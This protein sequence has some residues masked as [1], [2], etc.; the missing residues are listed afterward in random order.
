MRLARCPSVKSSRSSVCSHKNMTLKQLF[1]LILSIALVAGAVFFS[2]NPN[3]K[4]IL[5][6]INPFQATL[7]PMPEEEINDAQEGLSED[8]NQLQEQF[9]ELSERFNDLEGKFLELSSINALLSSNLEAE[10]LSLSDKPDEEEDLE[11]GSN[12]VVSDKEQ[13]FCDVAGGAQPAKNTV[14][15]NE[16]AWMGTIVSANDEWLEMKNLSSNAINLEG[17]QILDKDNQIKIV[18]DGVNKISANNL[19]ILERTDDNSLPNVPAGRIYSGALSDSNEALYLF[20]QNCD[21][22]DTVT[23]NPDWFSGD[24]TTKRTMERKSDFSWQTSKDTGGTPNQENSSGYAGTFA[25]NN[26]NN[27]VSGSGG[28]GGNNTSPPPVV[29]PKLLISEVQIDPID[30][31]F[32][33]LYNPNESEVSLTGWYIQRKTETGSDWVSL[34]SSNQFDGKIISAQSHFLIAENGEGVDIVEALTVTENN[35]LILKNPNRDIVDK[36]GFGAAQDF[37]TAPAENPPADKSI[38]RLWQDD[39]NGYF[40]TDNNQNDFVILAPTPKNKNE[41]VEDNLE[42]QN[43]EENKEEEEEE[44]VVSYLDVVINEIAWMGTTVSANDEWLE[45]YNNTNH[46]IDLTGWVLKSTDGTPLIDITETDITRIVPANN[47]YLLERT[48]D[49]TV[50]DIPADSIYAGALGNTGEHLQLYDNAN[51]LIDEIDN[52]GGWFVGDNDSKQTMEKI[53][54]SGNGNDINNWATSFGALGTPKA[55]NSQYSS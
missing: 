11:Q 13:K 45:L 35:I 54:P 41:A 51:N 16:I 19:F 23:A 34:I 14:I 5:S 25:T 22:E 4:H 1:F 6:R 52:S 2:L 32:I 27:I 29:Y 37:E 8:L 55:Q 15:F 26:N 50:L 46:D 49:D 31:R 30:G 40:D 39:V 17:W 38:N 53:N 18:F 10:K 21:L 3:F 24:K 7:A 20:N 47:Y 48:S 44:P 9:S 42:Q 43:E 33:E 12:D 36:V 28:G